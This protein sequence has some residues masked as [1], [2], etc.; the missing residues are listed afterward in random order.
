VAKACAHALGAMGVD[1]AAPSDAA[2]RE[3][4]ALAAMA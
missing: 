3:R 2:L 4:G 1:C